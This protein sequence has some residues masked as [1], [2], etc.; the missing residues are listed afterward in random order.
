MKPE[1]HI[2][3]LFLPYSITLSQ[4]LRHESHHNGMAIKSLIVSGFFFLAHF[5]GN[6]ITKS[7]ETMI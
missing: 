6:H 3:F 2:I 5:D 1:T 7:K 4:Q